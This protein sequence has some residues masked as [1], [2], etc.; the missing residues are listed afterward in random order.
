MEGHAAIQTTYRKQLARTLV[1]LSI[2]QGYTLSV[3]A[4][5]AVAANH[6]G[7]PFLTEAWG[8]VVGAVLA[9]VLL[10][11]ATG[12]Q[13]EHELMQLAPRGRALL[14]VVPIVVVLATGA[15]VSTVPW[16][17]IGFLLA[18]A[19]AAGGYALMVS[20]FIGL[21]NRTQAAGRS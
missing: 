10:V 2:P 20:A 13:S 6:Y 7:S 4:T 14:N 21:V 15:V 19:M 11:I 1:G 18:G 3:S 17:G 16:P 5:F 9:F 12:E 8:F